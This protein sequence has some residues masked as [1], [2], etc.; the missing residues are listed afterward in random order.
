[1]ATLRHRLEA[2]ES[3]V[4]SHLDA[5]E[6]VVAI[7][8][9]EDITLH[10]GIE[11]GGAA[12]TLL[13]VT[14]RHVRWVPR[15]IPEY[16]ASLPFGDVRGYSEAYAAHRYA[17]TLDHAAVTRRAWAPAHRVLGFRWGIAFGRFL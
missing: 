7:G 12:W 2:C 8:R 9:C 1:M 4:L 13:I 14:D 10:G 3:V 11:S 15:S 17:I 16:E 6:H 5:G